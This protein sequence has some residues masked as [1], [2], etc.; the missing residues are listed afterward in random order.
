MWMRKSEEQLARERRGVWRSFR[1][2]AVLFL[3]CFLADVGIAI[4]GPRQGTGPVHWPKTFSEIL[5]GATF[6]ATV[7]AI[8]WY[9][10]QLVL[11]R[12]LNPLVLASKLGDRT[13]YDDVV[14]CDSC[15]RVK[16]GDNESNC[17]CGGVFDDF[18]K[19]T[20]VDD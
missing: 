3:I 13:N 8:G 20:W 2:P 14:I 15:Y 16:H 12:R 9:T 5:G 17:E 4:Q 1:G 10:L 11:R 18:D 6:V 19:W 7:A